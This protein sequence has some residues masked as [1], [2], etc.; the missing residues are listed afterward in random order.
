[1]TKVIDETIEAADAVDAD[2]KKALGEIKQHLSSGSNLYIYITMLFSLLLFV[3]MVVFIR[4]S[5]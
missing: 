2:M 4:M 1:M 3:I 5:V